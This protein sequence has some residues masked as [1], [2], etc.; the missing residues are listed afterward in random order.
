MSYL[1]IVSIDNI[2]NIAIIMDSLS[3]TINTS[4]IPD[5]IN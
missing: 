1:L 2:D 4:F 5:P 3:W